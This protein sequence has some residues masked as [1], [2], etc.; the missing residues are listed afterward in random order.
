L[1]GKEKIPNRNSPSLKFSVSAII[2]DTEIVS[3]DSRR[4]HTG[5]MKKY[6]PVGPQ[7]HNEHAHLF[8]SLTH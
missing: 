1:L 4:T 6:N 7:K 8:S 2:D 3:S 5:D